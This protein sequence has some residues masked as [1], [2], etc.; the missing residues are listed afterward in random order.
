M[1]NLLPKTKFTTL[2]RITIINLKNIYISLILLSI[3]LF[4]LTIPCAAIEQ[5]FGYIS[6]A[7]VN[8]R[9][10]KS[11]LEEQ[12]YQ[13]AADEFEKCI[14]LYST[15]SADQPVIDSLRYFTGY[16]YR[17][18]NL[19]DKS[20]A[21]MMKVQSG[22]D[23]INTKAALLMSA[24]YFNA[25]KYQLS[26]NTIKPINS[27]TLS[28][29]LRYEINRLRIANYLVQNDLN[30]VN[31]DADKVTYSDS[32]RFSNIVD[33]IKSSK[34]KSE[35]LAGA[36]SAIVPGSGKVYTDRSLDGLYSFLL[37]AFTGWRTYEG[38]NAKGFESVNFWLFGTMGTYFY[39]GNVYGSVV[40][41]TQ[42]N[43]KLTKRTIKELNE[44]VNSEY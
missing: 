28:S 8:Y 36:L 40:S 19:Y 20:N 22:S 11:L 5:E 41:A 18:I 7:D 3:F 26:Q 32:I 25:A 6:Q 30:K 29:D 16:A 1:L 27:S 33:D 43:D 2:W 24:N 23:I 35:L 15:L 39:L 44:I 31:M 37:I 17:K 38:Y 12:D 4:V 10:A 34:H 14:Y 9:F 42:Y 21:F 13:R